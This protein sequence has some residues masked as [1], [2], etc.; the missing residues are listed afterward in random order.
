[1]SVGKRETKEIEGLE[2]G[3]YYMSVT[4][5]MEFADRL[6]KAIG[7][8]G[9]VLPKQG[10]FLDKEVMVVIDVIV[11]MLMKLDGKGFGKLLKDALQFCYVVEDGQEKGLKGDIYETHFMGQLDVLG[12][13]FAF[14]LQVQYGSFFKRRAPAAE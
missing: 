5:A 14:F 8:A 10:G 7:P 9:D 6:A 13:V 3:C 12:Q 11:K 4:Q 2:Y 1:M